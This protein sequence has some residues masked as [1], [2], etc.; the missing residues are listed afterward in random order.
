M[1][2]L[3]NRRQILY[4][5]AHKRWCN[6][7]QKW[8]NKCHRL[9][10]VTSHGLIYRNLLTQNTKNVRAYAKQNT[11]E[12]TLPH[13]HNKKKLVEA[14]AARTKLEKKEFW[15]NKVPKSVNRCREYN[16]SDA[17]KRK[18]RKFRICRMPATTNEHRTAACRWIYRHIVGQ[19][20]KKL[21]HAIRNQLKL[22]FIYFSMLTIYI[23]YDYWKSLSVLRD[24]ISINKRLQRTTVDLLYATEMHFFTS[25]SKNMLF[26]L[27]NFLH[28]FRNCICILV[29]SIRFPALNAKHNVNHQNVEI[30]TNIW[31][32]IDVHTAC[33]VR[34]QGKNAFHSLCVVLKMHR[35]ALVVHSSSSVHLCNVCV[36]CQEPLSV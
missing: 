3:L 31:N 11:N 36:K 22:N 8:I 9:S 20:S 17:W 5:I 12:Q 6:G 23:A 14:G 19:S 21:F 24:Q 34:T 26:I 16:T 33:T 2:S 27:R 18:T 7:R 4:R 35:N 1:P 15:A 32:G 13:F 10:A 28:D 30:K 29:W 25:I